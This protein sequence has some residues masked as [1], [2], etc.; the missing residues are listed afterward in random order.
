MTHHVTHNSPRYKYIDTLVYHTLDSKV[1]SSLA[2]Q[3]YVVSFS[4]LLIHVNIGGLKPADV[5]LGPFH[6][7]LWLHQCCGT[8]S[9]SQPDVGETW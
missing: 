8:L 1:F 2:C 7:H 9:F 6:I 5:L 4:F 3:L